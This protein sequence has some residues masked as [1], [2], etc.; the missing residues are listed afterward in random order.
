MMKQN[1]SFIFGVIMANESSSA[2]GSKNNSANAKNIVRGIVG[3]VAVIALAAAGYDYMQKTQFQES[4]EAVRELFK[5]KKTDV[6][7]SITD[8]PEVLTGSPKLIGNPKTDAEV[9]YR[10]GL[11]RD[12]DMKLLIEADGHGNRMVGAIE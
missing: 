6:G 9:T 7:M 2:N 12:Y 1:L 3:V 8:V 11:I 5:E 10:W 4:S